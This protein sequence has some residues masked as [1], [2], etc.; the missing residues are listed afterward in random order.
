M[1]LFPELFVPTRIFM[2]SSGIST[3]LRF[4]NRR[5]VIDLSMFDS[6]KNI[7]SGRNLPFVNGTKLLYSTSSAQQSVYSQQP[8][9]AKARFWPIFSCR[10]GTQLTQADTLA[11]CWLR[12]PGLLAVSPWRS[13]AI[14]LY[15]AW[16]LNERYGLY[17]NE[18]VSLRSYLAVSIIPQNR[19]T[20]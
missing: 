3:S 12:H 5:M 6:E 17:R 11:Q 20:R 18:F 2:R 8:S 9:T 1:L 13:L 14:S 15:Q 19:H 10:E 16:V 4:L 7:S